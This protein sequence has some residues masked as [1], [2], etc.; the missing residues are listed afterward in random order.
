MEESYGFLTKGDGAESG[1]TYLKR[2]GRG[3][4][5]LEI[6]IILPF[7]RYYGFLATAED[8]EQ[9]LRLQTAFHEQMTRGDID[10]I[11]DSSDE[12][13]QKKVS[14]T[15]HE[16][17][18]TIIAQRLGSPLDC[19][20]SRTAVRLWPRSRIIRSECRTRFSSGFTV[21]ETFCWKKTGDDYR[22]Y[23]YAL[24]AN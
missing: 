24:K 2:F 19:E 4:L 21:V 20:Q 14:R 8:R 5:L 1:W 7:V 17:S 18:F 11:Y 12:H 3:F 9:A 15:S 13:Y 22:L 16:E 23:I 10:G 6:L